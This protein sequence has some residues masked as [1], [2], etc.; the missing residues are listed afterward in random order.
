MA[1]RPLSP[2]QKAARGETRPSRVSVKV[3]EF[4]NVDRVPDPPGWLNEHGQALWKD[5]AGALYAQRVLTKADVHALAHLCQLH[6]EIVRDYQRGVEVTAANLAQLRMYFTEF[7][8]TPASRV[9]TGKG[10]D[11]DASNPFSR[12][13]KKPAQGGA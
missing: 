9:R 2:E 10:N 7:G 11:G 5:M 6:G 3:L 8:M 1:R 12:N 4:P 13:G